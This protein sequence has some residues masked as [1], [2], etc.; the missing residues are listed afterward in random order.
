MKDPDTPINGRSPEGVWAEVR[1][2]RHKGT[3]VKRKKIPRERNAG[4]CAGHVEFSLAKPGRGD[5]PGRSLSKHQRL[6][7]VLF[8][9]SNV[10]QLA[11]SHHRNNHGHTSRL[12]SAAVSGRGD[13]GGMWN[14]ALQWPYNQL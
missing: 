2:A 11:I 13:G 12:Y 9:S 10:R 3:L 14:L 1:Q 5:E 6:L 8:L 7:A 4:Q